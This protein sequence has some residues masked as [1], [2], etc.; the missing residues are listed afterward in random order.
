MK[1]MLE[2]CRCFR[3]NGFVEFDLEQFKAEKESGNYIVGQDVT[4]PHCQ[5]TTP[6]SIANQSISDAPRA[7]ASESMI[8]AKATAPRSWGV[9]IMAGVV[10]LFGVIAFASGCFGAIS[11][12]HPE[13]AAVRQVTWVM[14]CCTG[15]T[16]F[17]CAVIID[18]LGKILH[19][20]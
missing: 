9:H 18:T 2:K 8:E 13:A 7:S 12:P 15:V 6:L 11:E 5:Q 14:Q 19:R 20:L 3:C 16:L 1:I 17:A 10:L 4:C